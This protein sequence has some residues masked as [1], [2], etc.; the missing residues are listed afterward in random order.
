MPLLPDVQQRYGE[1]YLVIHR[2]DLH[3]VLLD[4]AYKAGVKIILDTFVSIINEAEPSVIL[5]DGTK[6]T[7]DLIIGADGLK[8][9]AR[10]AVLN[11]Q[12][13]NIRF[14]PS[15][16]YR[17]LIPAASLRSN[18]DLE[19]LIDHANAIYW[20][21]PQAHVVAYPISNSTMYNFV[22]CDSSTPSVG[23]VAKVVPLSELQTR[24]GD[25]DPLVRQ[26]IDLVPEP[27]KWQLAE[28]EE[29]PTW[30]S[31][32]GRLVV[33]GDASHAMVPHLAQGAA[34]AL[35]DAA[36]L[37]E[38]VDRAADR[39]DLPVL[40][41]HFQDI[42][43]DRCYRIQREAR[44]LGEMWHIPDGPEQERRDQDMRQASLEDSWSVATSDNPN[45]WGDAKFQPYLF[46]YDAFQEAI[47]HL[48]T[49][50]KQPQR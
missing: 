19:P 44:E 32:S 3:K 46:G 48:D 40:M 11:G 5:G 18:P 36:A 13:V 42:R 50:Y 20:V 22:L 29:S 47:T 38:C 2:A 6:L 26:L 43:R 33:I 7:A 34:M 12:D 17:T 49:H 15:C 14:S 24:F 1:P 45:R 30:V 37:A 16:V 28:I 21:G 9:H 10:K 4:R 31:T 27:L 8:S 23:L 35:E 39:T 25:W 41:G